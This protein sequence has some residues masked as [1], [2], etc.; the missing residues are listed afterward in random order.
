MP[1]ATVAR[2]QGGT[3]RPTAVKPRTSTRA[4][5]RAVTGR[6]AR[7]VEGTNSVEVKAMI[8]DDHIRAG[9]RHLGLS[10]ESAVQ[11]LVYFFDTPRLDLF[12]AGV[13]VRARRVPGGQHDS[14]IKIRPVRADAVPAKWKKEK[15]FKLE[16]DAGE[17]A[18][19][20]SAS[21]SRGVEKGVIKQVAAGKAKVSDLFSRAQRQFLAEMCRIKT[22][23]DKLAI[24]GPVTVQWWKVA[25]PRV[26]VAITSELWTRADKVQMLETSIRVPAAQAAFATGGFAAFLAE[27]GARLE[28]AQQ[29]KTRWALE[30]YAAHVD[31]SGLAKTAPGNKQKSKSPSR[32]IAVAKFKP[33]AK[34]AANPA[35]RKKPRVAASAVPHAEP[36]PQATNDAGHSTEAQ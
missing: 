32:D 1:A 27:V 6:F 12:R 24:L 36:A 14:T 2:K 25:N 22:D 33:A 35:V 7:E 3:T 9:L 15:G 21:L 13:I 5:G 28:N 18:I 23:L 11:R 4:R 20:R 17:N 10:P 34:P 16:A 29:A 26:P 19:V 31:G 8:D 30:Y